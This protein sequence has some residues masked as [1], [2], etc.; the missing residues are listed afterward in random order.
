MQLQEKTLCIYYLQQVAR[1]DQK[2]KQAQEDKIMIINLIYYFLMIGTAFWL[3][4]V[5]W[6]FKG[7]TDKEDKFAAKVVI[8]IGIIFMI[9]ITVIKICLSS[10]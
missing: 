1:Q 2:K 5:W 4:Y 6:C 10:F 7:S 3:T 8:G 9:L